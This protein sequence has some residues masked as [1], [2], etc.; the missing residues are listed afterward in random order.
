MKDFKSEQ[1][2]HRREVFSAILRE[3]EFGDLEEG[4]KKPLVS[5]R[6]LRQ[7]G[8]RKE[9]IGKYIIHGEFE[10]AGSSDPDSNLEYDSDLEEQSGEMQE[11][12]NFNII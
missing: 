7:G 8:R 3:E 12:G 1:K 9:R 4:E 2:K 10:C 11:I 6:K 5:L